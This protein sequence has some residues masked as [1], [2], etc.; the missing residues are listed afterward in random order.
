MLMSTF[1]I[2]HNVCHGVDDRPH[3]ALGNSMQSGMDGPE[4]QPVLR[5]KGSTRSA[6][7]L[8]C[9]VMYHTPSREQCLSLRDCEL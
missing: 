7:F 5:C 4:H 9:P 6:P 3:W 2:E 8:T 1:I